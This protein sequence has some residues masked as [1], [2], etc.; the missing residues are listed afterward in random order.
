M[1][2]LLPAGRE[3]VEV[4]NVSNPKTGAGGVERGGGNSLEPCTVYYLSLQHYPEPFV[5]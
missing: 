5:S 2:G 1:S 4:A 3:S